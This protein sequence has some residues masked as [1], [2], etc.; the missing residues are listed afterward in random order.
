MIDSK[1]KTPFTLK[2]VLPKCT[3]CGRP[4]VYRRRTSGEYFC[5]SCF[6]K[7]FTR[8]IRKTIAEYTMLTPMSHILLFFS[9]DIP[10]TS[11]VM[12]D[13][14]IR[15]E[16][17]YPTKISISLPLDYGEIDQVKK[18]IESNYCGLGDKINIVVGN[19]AKFFTTCNS[20][21]ERY[22]LSRIISLTLAQ[23]I[24]AD[25]ILLPYSLE[26]LAILV[27]A[28]ILSARLDSV[29][30]IEPSIRLLENV[31]GYPLYD[32]PWDDIVFYSFVREIAKLDLASNIYS[33][34]NKIEKR[35]ST[36][37]R[38]LA[39]LSR[40]LAY[41]VLKN[42]SVFREALKIEE[43]VPECVG[44]IHR[45][46]AN[47]CKRLRSLVENIRVEVLSPCQLGRI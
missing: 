17:E 36:I 9:P 14:I 10:Y 42:P 35:A 46:R 25:S 41:N 8:R 28:N 16:R 13:S 11:L 6:L 45:S 34:C 32:T 30:Y 3:Y 44:R 24:S 29:A 2:K 40:E 31:I 47:E 43:I 38:E 33:R 20:F 15:L 26:S 19:Y 4:A 18:Y 12:I 27:L 22:M 7:A 5:S 23:E 1:F 21:Y 39:L 37:Y